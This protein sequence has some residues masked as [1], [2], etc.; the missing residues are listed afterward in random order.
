MNFKL[1]TFLKIVL[2]EEKSMAL[3][4][5]SKVKLMEN[6]EFSADHEISKNKPL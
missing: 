2:K 4:Y 5:N 1:G 3:G 6:G